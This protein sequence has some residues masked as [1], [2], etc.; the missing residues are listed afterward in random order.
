MNQILKDAAMVYGDLLAKGC[1]ITIA[2]GE[3]GD[4]ALTKFG[5]LLHAEGYQAIR[6]CFEPGA[7]WSDSRRHRLLGMGRICD[8]QLVWNVDASKG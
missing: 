5:E 4:E 2:P 1:E 7:R 3:T 8:L 6:E